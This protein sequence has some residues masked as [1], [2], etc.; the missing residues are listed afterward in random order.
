MDRWIE[1]LRVRAKNVQHG[2]S[3]YLHVSPT[4]WLLQQGHLVIRQIRVKL[5]GTSQLASFGLSGARQKR[6]PF[7]QVPGR[8]RILS[9]Y[10]GLWPPLYVSK[11]EKHI[12]ASATEPSFCVTNRRMGRLVEMETIHTLR[13]V[14]SCIWSSYEV[15][16]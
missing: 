7:I 4:K 2:I 8:L 11:P 1:F 15:E 5:H 12:D 16:G 9:I 3:H 13:A 10:G 14:T 6:T